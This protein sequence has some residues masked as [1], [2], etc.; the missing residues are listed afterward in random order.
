MLSFLVSSPVQSMALPALG[1]GLGG[2]P[3]A[4]VRGRIEVALG[5]VALHV[6]VYEPL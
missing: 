6:Q 3:W 4:I 2:L 5:K 1:S